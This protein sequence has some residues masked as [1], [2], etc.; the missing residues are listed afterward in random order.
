MPDNQ[1]MGI[2]KSETLE[3]LIEAGSQISENERSIT[4]QSLT[5]VRTENTG[6]KLIYGDTR[7]IIDLTA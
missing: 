1:I 3:E 7:E 6:Y 4:N 2:T 5:Y